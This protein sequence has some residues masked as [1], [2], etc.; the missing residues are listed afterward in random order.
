MGRQAVRYRW[1]GRQSGIGGQAGRRAVRYRWAGGQSG[2][3]GQA[4]SQV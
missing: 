1:A 2:I 4:G 3:G